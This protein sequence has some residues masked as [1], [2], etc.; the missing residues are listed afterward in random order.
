M[1]RFHFPYLGC[2][3]TIPHRTTGEMRS[4]RIPSEH[5]GFWL[6]II[7]E[8]PPP[9]PAQHPFFG[10]C[11]LGVANETTIVCARVAV[12]QAPLSLSRRPSLFG[13]VTRSPSGSVGHVVNVF[14]CHPNT[15]LR[16]LRLHI[17]TSRR[18]RRRCP[19]G[20][21]SSQRKIRASYETGLNVCSSTRHI[22]T[23]I[24]TVVE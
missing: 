5:L 13:K 15:H 9:R 1:G 23:S 18:R 6:Y 8:G 7:D 16:G 11:V 24:Y 20:L 4:S 19:L 21:S 17:R 3:L 12:T 10:L 14:L 2:H 22:S